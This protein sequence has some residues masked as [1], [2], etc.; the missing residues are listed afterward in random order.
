MAEFSP[1]IRHLRAIYEVAR[2][3]SISRASEVMYLSQPAI[4]Q[5]VAKIE[6]SLGVPLFER[7]S[8]GVFPTE[9]GELLLRRIGRAIDIIAA[10]AAAALK[11]ASSTEQKA[12]FDNFANLVTTVQLRSIIAVEKAGNF[13]LAARLEGVTQPSLHRAARDLER[14]SGIEFYVKNKSGIALTQS[15]KHFAQ[16]AQLA[17]VELKQG[18]DEIQE[19]LGRDSAKLIVGAMPLARATIL[20]HAI[21]AISASNPA[22]SVNIVDGPYSDLLMWLR[23]G[24]LDFLVGAMRPE[25][26]V[27]DVEQKKLFVDTLVAVARPEHP[28]CS[29]TKLDFEDLAVCQWAVP[30]EGTPA[31]DCFTAMFERAGMGEPVGLVETSSL[32]LIRNL[33]NNSDRITLI[34]KYQI[35]PEIELGLLKVLDINIEDTYREIGVTTRRDWLPTPTQKAFLR[36]VEEAVQN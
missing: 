31:R 32:M 21:N 8:G 5:A 35:A 12:G 19:W 2:Y 15:A 34:S 23:R 10:G 27:E 11:A 14:L 29:K 3:N 28:L 13:S 6:K 24:E 26:P 18:H 25:L 16:S 4:T 1:N 7:R 30:R 22:V 36:H 9:P 17:L 33:L 20:P